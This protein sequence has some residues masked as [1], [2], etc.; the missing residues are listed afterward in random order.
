[1]INCAFLLSLRHS[2]TQPIYSAIVVEEF[3][4]SNRA[5]NQNLMLSARQDLSG[6]RSS[7][8]YFLKFELF[9]RMN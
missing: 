5:F 7:R 4:K 1:M 6:F 2:L 8:E 9:F 3:M